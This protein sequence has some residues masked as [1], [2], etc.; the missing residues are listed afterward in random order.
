MH[1][2]YFSSVIVHHT[3]YPPVKKDLIFIRMCD[4]ITAKSKIKSLLMQVHAAGRDRLA[5]GCISSGLS[6][7]ADPDVFL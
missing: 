3:A 4:T 1:L 5:F 7:Y 6:R 2:F